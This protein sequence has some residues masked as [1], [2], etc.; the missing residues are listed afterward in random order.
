MWMD[1]KSGIRSPYTEFLISVLNRKNS[2][3][4]E[5][6]KKLLLFMGDDTHMSEKVRDPDKQDRE[7]VSREIG[8]QP[9]WED[10][11]IQKALITANMNR[12]LLI[13]EY[14]SRL[15]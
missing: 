6:R 10:M 7:K 15:G 9:A 13:G 14:K 3:V 5:S 8:L 11:H 12:R 2:Q 4:S 1:M